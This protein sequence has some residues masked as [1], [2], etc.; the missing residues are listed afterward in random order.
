MPTRQCVVWKAACPGIV[1][2]P[3]RAP[4]KDG[5]LEAQVEGMVRRE[6]DGEERAFGAE[7]GLW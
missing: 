7:S 5:E 1:Y 2:V 6:K 3:S 4:P